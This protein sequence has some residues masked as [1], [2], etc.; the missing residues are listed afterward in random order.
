MIRLQVF[1]DNTLPAPVA[2][3]SSRRWARRDE[4]TRR[5]HCRN[6]MAREGVNSEAVSPVSV[7]NRN[8]FCRSC[9]YAR[10]VLGEYARTA[11]NRRNSLTSFTGSPDASTRRTCG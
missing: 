6:S 11:S 9:A 3:P 5:S 1:A 2:S 10:T 8:S 7:R 4:E